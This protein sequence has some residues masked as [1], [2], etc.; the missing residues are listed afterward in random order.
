M[1]GKDSEF[2]CGGKT[3]VIDNKTEPLCA[4][5]PFMDTWSNPLLQRGIPT[6]QRAMITK[7]RSRTTAITFHPHPQVPFYQSVS[8]NKNSVLP[9]TL[10]DTIADAEENGG[11]TRRHMATTARFGLTQNCDNRVLGGT[12]PVPPIKSATLVPAKR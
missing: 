11:V 4:D 3:A 2:Q 6:S 12:L 10:F 1:Q 8:G 9:N 5:D 7:A